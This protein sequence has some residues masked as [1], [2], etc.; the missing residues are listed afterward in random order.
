MKRVWRL[1]RICAVSFALA[2]AAAVGLPGGGPRAW[3]D[4]LLVIAETSGGPSISLP[5]AAASFDSLEAVSNALTEDRQRVT[6]LEERLR[7]L[8]AKSAPEALP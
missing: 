4:D 3:A 6:A 1:S 5:S 7:Q 8:E 2:S